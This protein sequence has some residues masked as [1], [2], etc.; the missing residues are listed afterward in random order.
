[1]PLL[2]IPAQ[3]AYNPSVLW[4]QV[5]PCLEIRPPPSHHNR[6]RRAAARRVVP[7][8]RRADGAADGIEGEGGRAAVLRMPE[9]MTSGTA[10]PTSP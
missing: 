8:M 9:L 6:Q 4:S 5:A 10:F 3:A 1:M 2:H 7:E